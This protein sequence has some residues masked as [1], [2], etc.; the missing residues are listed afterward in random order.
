MIAAI[1]LVIG[2]I[3]GYLLKAAISRFTTIGTLRIDRSDPFDGPHM[4]LELSKTVNDISNKKC[5]TLK[6]SNKNYISQK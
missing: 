4:F 2:F 5:I 3:I 1:T 6:V